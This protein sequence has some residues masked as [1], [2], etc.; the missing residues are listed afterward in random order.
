[1][2]L[3]LLAL[4]E[5][6]ELKIK[7]IC[8]NA[9]CPYILEPQ[10]TLRKFFSVMVILSAI[11]QSVVL[12][13]YISFERKIPPTLKALLFFFDCIYL[14]DIYLQ[15][16]TLIRGRITTMSTFTSIMLY[17]FKELSFLIDIIAIFPID[18]IVSAFDV[19]DH[20]EA[21]LK[22]N[23][24]LKIHI[25][26]AFIMHQEKD[27]RRNFLVLQLLKYMILYFFTSKYF[28]LNT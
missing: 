9:Q 13:Y 22:L 11:F 23:R 12:P 20:T 27:F 28:L 21:L 17:R 15:L 4:A 18:Y 5:D 26:F 16:T 3:G 6:V 1:M 14:L 19:S 2:N 10:S 8:L 25:F 7:A 24:I